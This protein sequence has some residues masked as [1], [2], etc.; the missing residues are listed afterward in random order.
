MKLKTEKDVKKLIELA[1]EARENSY[2]PYSN[3][4]V[5][6]CLLASSGKTYKGANIENACGTSN[7]AERSAFYTACSCGE[8]QFD[9][10]AV[11]GSTPNDY[12]FPCGICRQILSEFGDIKVIVAK[13][14]DD[15]KVFYLSELLP[16]SFGKDNLN[17]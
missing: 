4:K 13:T 11:V 8:R 17:N 9:A 6:A 2:S 7:C 12:T 16:N 5:G 15:Y 10:I 1:F 14:V 3:F